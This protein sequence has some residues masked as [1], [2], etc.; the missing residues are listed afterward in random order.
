MVKAK[1]E[2]V[3]YSE[4]SNVTE[5]VCAFSGTVTISPPVDG[6]VVA[7]VVPTTVTVVG[8]TDTYTSVTIT[9][10][11]AV[12]GVTRTFSSSTA[13]TSWTDSGWLANPAGPY[14]ITA[15]VTNASNC[16][17]TATISV[18]AGSS[19]GCCL[20][21]F[22]TTTTNATCAK[23]P[24]GCKEVS[25]RIGNDRCLTAVSVTTMNVAWTDYSGNKPRWQT[26]AF[27]GSTI[28]APGSW[29]TTYAGSPNEAGTAS[30]SNFSAPSPQVPYAVPMTDANTTRVTYVFN[31]A[32]DSGNGANRKVDVFGTNQYVFTL[33]DSAG[34]PSGIT[35]TCSL[36][37]L[38]VQ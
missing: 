29:T 32:T 36:G 7:G 37:Q 26:A 28:A 11:H 21:L 14:T 22:P 38:T 6:T 15:T 31:L 24:V 9:Y 13:G 1:D 10:M 23:N 12:Y 5:A 27:N 34:N 8:G 19:V 17:F 30:K 18:N 35:T 25:Y 4:A 16:S 2:C 20:S 33:L 3:N